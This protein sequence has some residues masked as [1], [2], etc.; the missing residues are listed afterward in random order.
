LFGRYREGAEFFTRNVELLRGDRARERFGM[1]QLPAVHSRTC[2]VWALSELGEFE[3]AVTI[4]REGVRLATEA[5][6]P[7]SIVVA[8]AGAGILHLIRGENDAAVTELE[9]AL[10]L[11]RTW[12][13]PLWFP[14]VASALGV[15]Y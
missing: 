11:V 6:H 3:D 12:R 8:R 4:A 5:G 1:P 9:Q 15:V 10:Q 2:L 13:T 7:L 14:R